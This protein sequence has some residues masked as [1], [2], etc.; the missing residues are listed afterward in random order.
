MKY[1]I[2]ATTTNYIKNGSKWIKQDKRTENVTEDYYTNYVDAKSL[3]KVIGARETH[4]KDYT[5]KGYIV[6]EVQSISPDRQ[7]K[8]C[9]Q[10]DFNRIQEKWAFA[11]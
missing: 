2:T 3:F 1:Q 9:T 11:N 8:I 6:T 5:C 10:F 7:S 4:K